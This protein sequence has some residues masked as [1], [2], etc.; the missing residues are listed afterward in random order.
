[1]IILH[2]NFGDITLTLN[3]EKAPVTAANFTQL[4]EDG[5]YNN[6]I[7][8]RVIE[9]FMI[10]GGGFSASMKQKEGIATIDNEADNGL[11]NSIG[12]IAM[13]RTMDPNS[14]S[15]QFFI[16]LSENAFLNHT[17]K[18]MEGWGY[19]VFGEVK[20]GMNVVNQ[21]GSLSTTSK[22]GHQ[23]VPVEDVYIK[24]VTVEPSSDDTAEG[25]I[26]DTPADQ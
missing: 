19:C 2:T 9:G 6:I 1:M 10:Q 22:A 11:K 25:A 8:H 4:A 26:E 5:F 12:S 13:A 21:I 18:T 3:H 20:A 14:A 7:F 15:S 16:N 23:D 24:S 17:T